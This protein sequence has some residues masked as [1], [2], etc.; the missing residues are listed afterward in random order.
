MI[1]LI[2]ENSLTEEMPKQDITRRDPSAW[3]LLH[4]FLGP[5][6]GIIAVAVVTFATSG[7]LTATGTMGQWSLADYLIIPALLVAGLLPGW[8]FGFIPALLHAVIMLLLRRLIDCRSIW[9][10]FTPFVG[11]LSVFGPLLALAGMQTPDR[12]AE[13]AWMSLTG[14]IAAMGCMAIA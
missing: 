13:A 3:L 1:H 11:W 5:V 6:I 12:L 9:L 4:C 8:F 14:S 10:V 7:P 2:H